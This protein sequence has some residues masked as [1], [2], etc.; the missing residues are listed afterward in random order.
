MSGAGQ[1][2]GQASSQDEAVQSHAGQPGA[3]GIIETSTGGESE[4]Q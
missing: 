2:Q 3:V 4:Q 1:G